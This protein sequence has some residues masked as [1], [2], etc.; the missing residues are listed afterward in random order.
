MVSESSPLAKAALAAHNYFKNVGNPGQ[1][2]R[3]DQWAT[4][5]GGMAAAGVA[6]D[7]LGLF[8][9]DGIIGGSLKQSFV[10]LVNAGADTASAQT[11]YPVGHIHTGSLQPVAVLDDNGLVVGEASR[12]VGV[13]A[14]S[15]SNTTVT[16]KDGVEK[17]PVVDSSSSTTKLEISL[18]PDGSYTGKQVEE[19][20]KG[21]NE[22]VRGLDVEVKGL[23]KGQ[24]ATVTSGLSILV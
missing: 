4:H 2:G 10:D 13:E 12:A 18:D 17:T 20:L 23:K 8:G 9:L 14:S 15:G 19:L 6:N 5:F 21:L 7:V 24:E 16:D 22:K 3:P 1:F 11:G